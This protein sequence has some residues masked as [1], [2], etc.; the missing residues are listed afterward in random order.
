MPNWLEL[1]MTTTQPLSIANNTVQVPT[2]RVQRRY[3]D[4]D[5]EKDVCVFSSSSWAISVHCKRTLKAFALS[6]TD[7]VPMQAAINT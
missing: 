5:G 3:R 6:V 4:S 1:E 2:Q 7:H